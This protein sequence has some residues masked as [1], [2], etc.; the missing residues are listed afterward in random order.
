MLDITAEE[1]RDAFSLTSGADEGS[2][3]VDRSSAS[4]GPSSFMARTLALTPE[5]TNARQPYT[6]LHLQ[7]KGK[8]PIVVGTGTIDPKTV[9]KL[10]QQAV[11]HGADAR[12]V[13]TVMY[14]CGYV[15]FHVSTKRGLFTALPRRRP[16]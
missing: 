3:H 16:D 1:V 6:L 10:T 14:T 7:V 13:L 9:V 15:G 11:D 12:C 4:A 8:I 5:A 2:D